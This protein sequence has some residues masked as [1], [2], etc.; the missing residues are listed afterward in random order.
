MSVANHKF[1]DMKQIEFQQSGSSEVNAMLTQPLL[2][3]PST[4]TCEVTNLQ[5]TIGEEPFFPTGEWLFTIFR[6]PVG[7]KQPSLPSPPFETHIDSDV[8]KQ[9]VEKPFN[10][11][12]SDIF[13]SLDNT[14]VWCPNTFDDAGQ[15]MEF[16]NHNYPD[17]V[18]YFGGGDPYRQSDCYSVKYYSTMDFVTYCADFIKVYD[19]KIEAE[20]FS[21]YDH[22]QWEDEQQAHL[23]QHG[24]L[25]DFN[26][27]EPVPIIW[28][29]VPPT[30]RSHISLSVD[31]GG[32]LRFWMSPYFLNNYCVMTSPL[33]QRVTGFP[34]FIGWY[35]Y[36]DHIQTVVD[37]SLELA[38]IGGPINSLVQGNRAN[39]EFTE[40]RDV[41]PIH[42]GIDIRRKI[43]LEVSLP[44]SHTLS[45]DGVKEN[46]RYML[47]EFTIPSGAVSMSYTPYSGTT[48][49]DQDQRLGPLILL[50]GGSALAMKKL[51]EGQM[52]AFRIDI[53]VERRK[54]DSDTMK[55]TVESKRLDMGSGGFFYLKLLFSKE[56]V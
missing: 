34:T 44:V 17:V 18:R 35:D 10:F 11:Y 14:G 1:T 33:F 15:C 45:W 43:M 26:I 54:W 13:G 38:N 21:L 25:D 37:A 20:K 41:I 36:D 48:C 4:Y 28:T 22:A 50:N 5:C 46:T 12:D 19:R 47:Q 27:P 2:E 42:E 56:T 6:L 9:L 51:F 55:F 29:E 16:D 30:Q 52:Q 40:V 39:D 24:N 23:T 53:M 49:M 7:L 32:R 31:S 8:L 3:K